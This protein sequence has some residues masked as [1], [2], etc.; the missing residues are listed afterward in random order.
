[1]VDAVEKGRHVA[2]AP[3]EAELLRR[4]VLEVV[5]LV[6]HE[7]LVLRQHVPVHGDVG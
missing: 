4:L 7:V 5:R 2:V 1:M 3:L 6:D